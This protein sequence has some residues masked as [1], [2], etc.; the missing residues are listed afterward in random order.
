MGSMSNVTFQ[1]SKL[2]LKVE[3]DEFP[4]FLCWTPEAFPNLQHFYLGNVIPEPLM[5][6][7]VFPKLVHFYTN[8]DQPDYFW[9]QLL[10]AA[11]ELLYIHSDWLLDDVF[12]FEDLRP[13]LQIVHYR[14]ILGY[15][16]DVIAYYNEYF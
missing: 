6:K 2:A 8:V 14:N 10:E 3:P 13:A 1:A 11:P 16:S 12:R 5:R 15:T 9:R 7:G 4:A